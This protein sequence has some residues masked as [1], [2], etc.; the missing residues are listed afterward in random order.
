MTP[1]I[2]QSALFAHDLVYNPAETIFM[3]GAKPGPILN[4]L[5]C[6]CCQTRIAWQ[7]WNMALH[8]QFN[9]GVK[10]LKTENFSNGQAILLTV[11]NFFTYG[12]S[13]NGFIVFAIR[14]ALKRQ[15][16]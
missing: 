2:K 5:R 13:N 15:M 3:T 11:Y 10:L 16:N 4:G 7:I 1:G 9:V 6:W 12:F 14:L 8:Y